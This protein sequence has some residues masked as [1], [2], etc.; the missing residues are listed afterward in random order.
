LKR[1]FTRGDQEGGEVV[2]S[3]KKRKGSRGR[4]TLAK[5]KK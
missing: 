5:G 4:L 2:A 3:R 1:D